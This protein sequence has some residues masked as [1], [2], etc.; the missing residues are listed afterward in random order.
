MRET[1]VATSDEGG[2]VQLIVGLGNVGKE[3]EHTR[4]NIGFKVVDAYRKEKG[5]P[6]W[7]EKKRF[8]AFVS[9]EFIAGKKVVLVKPTTL[10][11]LSGEAVQSLKDFYKVPNADIT[12]IHDE[13]D[14]PFGTVKEKTGGGSAGNNGLKSIIKHVGE[15]FKRIRIGIK[16]AQLEKIDAADFVLSTFSKEEQK[17]LNPIIQEAVSR[18]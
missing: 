16:N 7:Q 15:D 2:F 9:E 1:P 18:L 12:V 13:L 17:Q 4:H 5:F 8:K 6:A 14:L 3:Y 11:N 10:M